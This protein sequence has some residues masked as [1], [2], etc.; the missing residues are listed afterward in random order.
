MGDCG[1]PYHVQQSVS[2][3]LL[4]CMEAARL[5]KESFPF[6]NKKKKRKKRKK[7]GDHIC[8]EDNLHVCCGPVLLFSHWTVKKKIKGKKIPLSIVF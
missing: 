4:I 3:Q 1:G 5:I 2:A 7:K 6:C 8:F